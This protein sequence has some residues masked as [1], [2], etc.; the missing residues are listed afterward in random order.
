MTDAF[1]EEQE[2]EQR[3]GGT[4]GRKVE[5]SLSGQASHSLER[6]RKT[7][8]NN[9]SLNYHWETKV[10]RIYSMDINNVKSFSFFVRYGRN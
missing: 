6:E 10:T 2:E 4:E 8:I 1:I 7:F 5:A 9:V 3:F